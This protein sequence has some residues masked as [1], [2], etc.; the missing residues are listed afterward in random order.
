MPSLERID[1]AKKLALRLGDKDGVLALLIA[2]A[3]LV[4]RFIKAIYN[5]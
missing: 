3:M 5:I 1:S 4:V 2:V